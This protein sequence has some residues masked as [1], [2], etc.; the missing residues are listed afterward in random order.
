MIRAKLVSIAAF[1]IVARSQELLIEFEQKING[2]LREKVAKL[3]LEV[4]EL[5]SK[6]LILITL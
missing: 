5:T 4:T 1:I 2:E 3:H 6:L